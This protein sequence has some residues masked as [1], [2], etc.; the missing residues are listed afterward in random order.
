MYVAYMCDYMYIMCV[1][2]YD[3]LIMIK[4]LIRRRLLTITM[5]SRI[6]LEQLQLTIPL[7]NDLQFQYTNKISQSK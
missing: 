4:K 2:I 7:N 6:E 3:S 1:T 5:F